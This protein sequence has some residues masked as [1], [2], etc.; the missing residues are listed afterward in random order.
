M[1]WQSLQLWRSNARLPLTTCSSSRS[2]FVS[3]ANWEWVSQVRPRKRTNEM[4]VPAQKISFATPWVMDPPP[5]VVTSP[6][7]ISQDVMSASLTFVP[8][9]RTAVAAGTARFWHESCCPAKMQ[10]R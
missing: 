7:I 3:E 5:Q 4:K 2:A 8:P 9:R 6:G 10:G 1:V